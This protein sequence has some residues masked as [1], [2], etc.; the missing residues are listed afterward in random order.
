[1][2]HFTWAW[3]TVTMSTGGLSVLIFNQPHQFP[4]LREIGLGIY[5]VNI[6]LFLLITAGLA[7]RFV[8]FPKTLTR[9]LTHPRESFFFP[10]LLL[11]IA[12]LITSTE[13]YVVPPN[14]GKLIDAIQGSFWAYMGLSIIVAVAQ[15]AFVFA[16]HRFRP[17]R[18]MMPTWILPIFP[19]MLTGTIAS[20]VADTQPDIAS[21]PII[22]AGLTC[23][24][25]GLSVAGMMYA[26]MVGR[27]FC[28]GLPGREH[29]PGL[30]MCVGPPAFTAL[31]LLGMANGLPEGFDIADRNGFADV[32]MLRALAVVAAVFL[33]ALSFWWFG[34]AALAVAAARPRYFHLGWWAAVFPNVGFTLATI[35]LGR[36]MG[37]DAILEVATGMSVLVAVTYVFVFCSLVRAVLVQDIMYPGRDEDF[38]D[39]S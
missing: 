19:V 30:F 27:L 1:M 26:L 2:K 17:F 35:S 39:N 20:V 14:A 34:I 18:S 7:T 15:Y 28:A 21:V 37:C 10:T 3:Y 5:M 33:W 32:D 4:G 31:A 13:R 8:L 36:A 16:R 6:L 24:G 11:S 12:T 9:S 29:R 22:V 23:Q 25:L 38:Q